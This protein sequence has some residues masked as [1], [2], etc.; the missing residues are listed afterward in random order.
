MLVIPATDDAETHIN[1]TTASLP[2]SGATLQQIVQETAEDPLLQKVSHHIK[3][4]WSK[5]V[6]PGFY[7]VRADLC[8]ANGLLL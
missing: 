5:G 7:P 4:G 2:T 6:C 1:M 3:N 8:M